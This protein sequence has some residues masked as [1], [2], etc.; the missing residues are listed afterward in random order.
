MRRFNGFELPRVLLPPQ[1]EALGITRARARTELRRGNWQRLASGILLTRPD[2]PTRSDWAQ[3]GVAL[4]PTGAAVTGWDVVRL[5]GIG[6]REP[7]GTHVLVVSSRGMH[8]V[9]GGVRIVRSARPY[10]YVVTAPGPGRWAEVPLVSTTRAVVDTALADSSRTRVRALVTSAVQR[11]A[12]RLED[13]LAELGA[14]PRRGSHNLR[15][16]LA[17]AR[18]GARSVAEARA[19][20]KLRRADVPAFELNVPVVIGGRVRFYVDVLWRELRAGLEI[21]GREYHFTEREWL[22]TIARHN[23]LVAGGLALQHAA[24]S[25]VNRSDWAGGIS[26]WLRARAADLGVPYCRGGVIAPPPG[27]TPPPLVLRA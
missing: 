2:E 18:D 15:L 5:H 6:D 19:V 16:A 8:R 14:A 23:E 10:R 27:R 4:A 20:G 11:R 1:A 24:P 26:E 17:D 12:C 9:V 7:P 22:A 13:L 3:V 21:D 25:V